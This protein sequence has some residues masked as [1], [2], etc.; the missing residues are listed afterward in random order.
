MLECDAALQSAS[1]GLPLLVH[2]LAAELE[3]R[4]AAGTEV[5]KTDTGVYEEPKLGFAVFAGAVLARF[6]RREVVL[7]V[8]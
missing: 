3:E 6:D 2:V 5:D 8:K 7:F 1:N 4:D